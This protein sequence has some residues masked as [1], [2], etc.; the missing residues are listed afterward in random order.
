MSQMAKKRELARQIFSD[1]LTDKLPHGLF[2]GNLQDIIKQLIEF[3]REYGIKYDGG[4]ALD[5]DIEYGY[6]DERSVRVRAFGSRT[7]TDEEYA[8]R[9]L[10]EKEVARMERKRAKERATENKA[11]EYETYLKL[12]DKFEKP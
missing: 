5:T 1:E 9:M 11:K 4:I 12:K 6:Y 3:D 8:A 10:N 7:E 2:S